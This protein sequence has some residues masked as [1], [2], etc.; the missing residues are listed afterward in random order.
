MLTL[1]DESVKSE[2][3]CRLVKNP[4]FTTANLEQILYDPNRMRGFG[5]RVNLNGTSSRLLLDTG[6]SGIVLDRKVAEKAGIKPVAESQATGIGDR[7][8]AAGYV[9][10]AES[11]TIGDLEFHGCYVH[12]INQGSVTGQEGLIGADIFS[13]FLVDLDFPDGKIKLSPLPARPDPP[14]TDGKPKPDSSGS[15]PHFHDR[16]VAPEMSSFSSIF[17]FGHKLL[18]KTIV[19]N[20]PPKLFL[21]D[22]GSFGNTISPAAA[23]EVTKVSSDSTLH[24]KGV[25]G[26]VKNVLRGEELTLQFA[27]MRQ[28]NKDIV[29][30]DLT[31]ISNS[32]GTEVSGILGFA[33]LRLLEIKIDYRD[34]LI[35]FEYGLNRKH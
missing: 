7:G 27:N 32:T 12:V 18:L 26:E 2:R 4:G 1:E 25:S 28:K 19:N 16:Y 29:A 35:E 21:V 23:G 14:P 22:T 13:S 3:P 10:Y 34:G 17:Q 31:N 20:L 15:T 30:F 24:V 11:V 5:L 33:M 9:G 6:A 8:A